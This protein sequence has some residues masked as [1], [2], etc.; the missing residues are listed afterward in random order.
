MK[1]NT[2]IMLSMVS[3]MALLSCRSEFDAIMESNDV[4]LKYKTAFDYFNKGKYNRAADLFESL[5]LSTSGTDRG[6]TVQY[7][8]GLSNYKDKDYYTAETNFQQFL[9]NYSISPFASHAEFLRLD[10]LFRSTYRY[11]LDQTPTH[12][13]ITAIEQYM[14][15]SA[16]TSNFGVCRVMLED[17]NERLDKKAFENAK[18]Y[19]KMEDY[20]ASRVA[21][22]NILRDDADNIYRE[23]VMYY[24]AMSS[25][26]YAELSVKSKQKERFLVFVDDY[27]NVIGEYPESSHR[28]ELD[29]LYEKVKNN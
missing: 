3:L 10:C 11:E 16:D 9:T 23:D 21:F 22:K 27:L 2:V 6:D 28:K 15:N 8:W 26:K 20:K 7:Y 14:K 13:A 25:Y 17:L 1:T 24:L 5:T 4:D 12:R 18:L 19:Y 29:A